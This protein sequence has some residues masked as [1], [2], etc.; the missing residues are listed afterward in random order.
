MT[1]VLLTGSN[2]FVGAGVLHHL[3]RETDWTFILPTTALHHGSQ[4][5]LNQVLKNYDD[6]RFQDPHNLGR[7][8]SSIT[9]LSGERV[10]VVHCDLSQPFDHSLFG[11]PRPD[12]ILN[13]A[14]ESHV[15]RSLAAPRGFI[16]NNVQL[17]TN[18]MEYA[19]ETKP[20]LVMHMSTD[21]TMGD[22]YEGQSHVEWSPVRPSNPYAASKAAQEAIGFSYWRAY[23]VP[24]VVTNTMNLICPPDVSFQD[25]EK[26]VP[27][28]AKRLLSGETV[29]IHVDSNGESG[30]RHWIDVRDFASAWLFLIRQLE[31]DSD[32][33]YYPNRPEFHHRF[34]I[35]GKRASNREVA[36]MVAR[37]LG[38]ED[39]DFRDVSFHET[40]PGHDPHY[41]LDATKLKNLGWEPRIPLEQTIREIVAGYRQ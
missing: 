36:E 2:G 38:V 13:I 16:L 22:A 41:S 3:L 17:Q 7:T 5:R 4:T 15:D 11:G 14:S 33:T 25:E 32:L 20:R 12:Y 39:P 6:F 21:E 8:R 1:R 40:R 24:L 19:R 26:F 23:G 28:V 37:E 18:V 35:A 10:S 27:M 9:G 34:N 30:S 31:G 29:D